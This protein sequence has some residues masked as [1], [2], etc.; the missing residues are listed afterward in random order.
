M[1][2]LLIKLSNKS[3]A[4][5]KGS[6]KSKMTMTLNGA[7]TITDKTMLN[8]AAASNPPKKPSTVLLGLISGTR[9]VLPKLD[10]IIYAKYPPLLFEKP[11][12][13][14]IRIY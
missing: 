4:N 2:D 9:G 1:L 8:K 7:D 5:A 3:P 10:P 13:I 11:L 6:N 14:L 12:E